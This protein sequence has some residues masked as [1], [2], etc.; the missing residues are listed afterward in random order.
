MELSKKTVLTNRNKWCYS[1]GG[2][3]DCMYALY[4][5]YLLTY[6][7]FAVNTTQAQFAAI[8]I[9]MI[10]CRVW[11]AINDPMMATIVE[12]SH[13]KW[14]KYKPWILVGAVLNGIITILLF[15]VRPTGLN[16]WSFVI[17]FGFMF[18]LWGMTYTMNDIGYW[19][20][21]PVLTSNEK[22]RINL[23]SL[24]QII[25]S[26]GAFTAAGLIPMF[27]NGNAVSA[28]SIIAL[29]VSLAFVG[30]QVVTILG[31]K[32]PPRYD[33]KED[34]TTE[35]ITLGKMFKILNI[36]KELLWIVLV[37]FFYYLGSG[38]LLVFGPNFFYFEFGYEIGGIK[39]TEF[40]VIYAVGTLSAQLTYQLY[41]KKFSKKQIELIGIILLCIGYVCLFMFGYVLPRDF[42][43]ILISGFLI[44]YGQMVFY[45]SVLVQMT[46]TIEYNEYLTGNKNES[47]VS[48]LRSFIAKLTGALQQAI[49]T[50]I[51]L[52][53]GLKVLSDQISHLELEKS[54]G[55]LSQSDVLNQAT[56]ITQTATDG[57]LFILRI[58]TVV[59]PLLLIVIAYVLVKKKYTLSEE[60]YSEIML[61]LEKRK[62]EIN[63]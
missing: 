21:L 20:M 47:I 9:I 15:S 19:S 35:K 12:N 51:L 6:I 58:G 11:D 55:M 27:T 24:M 13:L 53:S 22:D 44:F 28:Y 43:V 41:A 31:V 14:G 5:M 40:T 25:S 45:L 56:T 42:L 33:E 63:D 34:K 18:L 23:T 4:S 39:M 50:L 16:G 1:I 37:I 62:G 36:N 10:I 38:L 48:S 3:R 30:V 49:L 54:A 52:I 8:T 57:M 32:E 2:F 60:K 59:I 29:C 7:Q 17:F 26:I 61:E 46:N